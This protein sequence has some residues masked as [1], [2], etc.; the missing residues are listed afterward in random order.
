MQPSDGGG[1]V[2]GG[3][4]DG[5]ECD[6]WTDFGADGFGV[7]DDI[8]V[9]VVVVERVVQV[10]VV[11]VALISHSHMSEQNEVISPDHHL[12]IK[13]ESVKLFQFIKYTKGN[14]FHYAVTM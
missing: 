14:I 7:C 10:V 2:G 9:V 6:G 13:I 1:R 8:M 12:H 11:A 4:E 5:G 3:C